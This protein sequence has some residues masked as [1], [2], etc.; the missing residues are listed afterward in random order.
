MRPLEGVRVLDFS[1]LVPGPL[2]TLLLVDAG[3]DVIKVERPGRGDE[4]RSY[5]PKA[6][7][8]SIGFAL[9]NRGKRSIT[10]DLKAPD[11][12]ERLMPLLR[13]TDVLVEQY[14]PGVM[15]RFGLGYQALAAINPGLIYCS[16]TGYGQT[17]P[18]ANAAGHDLN[19]VA[20][21][22]MLSLA[23]GADGAPVLPAVQVGDIGGGAYPAVVNILLA[24]LERN[25]S[26]KGCHLDIAMAENLFAFQYW[27]LGS[28]VAEGQGPRPG[29]ELL[30][31][32]SPR[33]QIYRTA[34]GRFIAAAPLEDKF[35][36]TFCTIIGL[37]ED[38]RDDGRDPAA[39]IQAVAAAIA[40]R[41]AAHW[42]AAFAGKDVCCSIVS[43]MQD[44][45]A[46]DHF[47]ARGLFA[48][49]LV[50]EDGRTVPAVPTPIAASLRVDKT[51]AGY[52]A[53]GEAN[54]LLDPPS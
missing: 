35:W 8:D 19:F 18:K 11:A 42:R 26:G 17:G 46:D 3:A 13:T 14:R 12:V 36:E 40:S 45:M 1:T 49:G 39:T 29:G 15:D 20:D 7:P 23:A 16:I 27:A 6:G 9:L 53:L 48:R 54:H 50:V 30:T 38:W 21:S 44:A 41:D 10:L 32:G 34:D 22:G 2:A 25:R 24:L 33:Y 47:T 4:M 43:T 37:P 31:G 5:E 28:A 51:D 52:P